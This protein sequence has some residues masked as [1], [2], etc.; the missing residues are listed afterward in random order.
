[1]TQYECRRSNG[2]MNVLA[3]NREEKYIFETDERRT[4]MRDGETM[5]IAALLEKT[6]KNCTTDII[7]RRFSC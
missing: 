2:S 3:N 7:V 6:L 1:M 4:N 5:T